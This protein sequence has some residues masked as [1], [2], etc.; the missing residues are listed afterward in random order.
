MIQL[1]PEVPRNAWFDAARELAPTPLAIPAGS[2]FQRLTTLL[3]VHEQDAAALPGLLAEVAEN[4]SLR[5]IAERFTTALRQDIGGLGLPSALTEPSRSWPLLPPSMGPAAR[6]VYVPG[7]LATVPLVEE[8]H[9]T[10][11]IPAETSRATLA[12]FGRHLEIHRRV[13]GIVGLDTHWWLMLGWSGGLVDLGRVQGEWLDPATVSLHIPESGPLAPEAVDASLDRL[14]REWPGWFGTR[15]ERA[16]CE[17]WLLD[18]AL[19]ELLPESSN[20]VRFQRR[21]SLYDGGYVDDQNPLSFVFRRGHVPLPEGLAGLPR[22]TRLQR[23]IVDR[24]L[25]GAHWTVR[26]GYLDL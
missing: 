13:H 11:G 23:A 5:W 18:P 9:R 1:A 21:F 26:K 16:E 6:S 17:S 14:R 19:G 25:E 22:E 12:D 2:A 7:F 8:L 24:L 3:G 10:R 20:I 15:P 4:P